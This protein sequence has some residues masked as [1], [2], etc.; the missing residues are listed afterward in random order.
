MA[1]CIGLTGGI[2]SGKST[3]MDLFQGQGI[4]CI[5]AD[6]VV[7]ELLDKNQNIITAIK[8]HFGAEFI[9]EHTPPIRSMIRARIFTNDN[10]RKFLEQLIHPLVRLELEKARENVHTPYAIFAIPLLIESDMQD[11]VDRILVVDI[12]LSLQLERLVSR[13]GITTEEARSIINA[14]ISREERLKHADD[15]IDNTEPMEHLEQAVVLLH[16]KYLRLAEN[17]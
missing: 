15:V 13:D 16:S 7:S 5:D 14:Q 12:P 6:R 1:L 9:D 8:D 17:R 10:E 3:V 11:L 2:A 4:E